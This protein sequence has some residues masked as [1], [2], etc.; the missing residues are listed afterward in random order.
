MNTEVEILLN[1]KNGG[2]PIKAILID[3][4]KNGVKIKDN[5]NVLAFI[6]YTSISY[7]KFI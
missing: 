4:L 1:T 5:E 7:I 3:E 2:I 6:P